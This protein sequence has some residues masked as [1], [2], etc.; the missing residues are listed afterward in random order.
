MNSLLV[1]GSDTEVG[2]TAVT[3][4]LAAYWLAH[5][6]D[7]LALL[8]LVQTGTGDRERYQHL[9]ADL[10]QTSEELAPQCFETPVAPPIAATRAGRSVDLGAIWQTLTHL[11]QTRDFVL[12]EALGGLGSP[13][14]AELTVADVAAAWRLTSILVI[15]VKLGAIA[16]AVA[17]VAL[18]RQTQVDLHG[19]VLNC[20]TPIAPDRLADWAPIETITALTQVPVLGVLPFLEDP[21]DR[22]ALAAAASNLEIERLWPVSAPLLEIH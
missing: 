18:A 21:D 13:V 19:I 4:A 11:Q 9:F 15:P 20:S 12:I 22:S 1:T 8:K 17:N 16:Q 6:R 10:E 5:R 3:T 7:R 2:K 14:T